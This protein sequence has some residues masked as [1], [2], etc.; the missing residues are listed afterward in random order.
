MS[1]GMKNHSHLFL[2]HC[3]FLYGSTGYTAACS[4][5]S[6]GNYKKQAP[7]TDMLMKYDPW[8]QNVNFAAKTVSASSALQ[9]KWAAWGDLENISWT[10]NATAVEHAHQLQNS[11]TAY[12]EDCAT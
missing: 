5:E 9:L 3:L 8:H 1:I 6:T 2:V 12:K 4:I 10:P 7:E 11:E